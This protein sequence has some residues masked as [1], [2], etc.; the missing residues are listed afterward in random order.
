MFDIF[1]WSV[2]AGQA[3][4]DAGLENLDDDDTMDL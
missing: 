4:M 1:R 3:T 2:P